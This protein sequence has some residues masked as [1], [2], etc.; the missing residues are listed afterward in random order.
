M[1]ELR[2]VEGDAAH[3]LHLEVSPA[4]IGR[5]SDNQ[6][7]LKDFSVSRHHARL[8]QRG[9]LWWIVDLGSTNGVKVN[10]RYATDALLADGDEIQ[11]GN[12]AVSFSDKVSAQAAPVSSSTFLRPIEEFR[13]DFHLEREA[14]KPAPTSTAVSARE[15]VLEALAQVARTLL[16]VEELQPVLEKVMEAVFDQLSAE[17]AYILLFSPE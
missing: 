8:E 7:V 12:F 1:R 6:V 10:G 5:A 11:V 4:G 14:A 16:E 2:W 13:E 15:R 9:E 17:R 3:C